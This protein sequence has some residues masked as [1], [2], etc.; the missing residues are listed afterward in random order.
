MR[1]FPMKWKTLASMPHRLFF[2]GGACQGIAAVLWWLLE[3]SG[4]FGGFD[5]FLPWT[6]PPVWAH[7][8]LII[9]GFFSFFI[10]GFLFTFFPNWLDAESIPS[11]NYLLSFF[12]FSS[13]TVLFYVGL[14]F[15]KNIL[16]LAVLSAVAGWGIGAI[17]LIR[18]LLP[19]RTPEKIHLSLMTFF[20]ILGEVGLLSFLLWLLTDQP[21]WLKAA[22]VI[23]IWFFLLPLIV[24]VSHLVI[25]FFS[26]AALQ[27]YRVVQPL[28]LLSILLGGICL[29]GLWEG[30]QTRSSFWI[31]DTV[32]LLFAS[33]LSFV[34]SFWKSVDIKFLFML[35][36]S[37]A[38]F[39]VALVLDLLQSLT[40]LWSHETLSVLGFAPLHALTIGFFSSMVVGMSTRVT[41]GHS[42]RRVGVDGAAWRIFLLFQIA[43]LLRVLAD[44]FPAGGLFN[45]G[46]Y[47][48]S[49]LLWIAGISS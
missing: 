24:T 41:L 43:A 32:L 36:L 47:E 44:L 25:P 35:H 11:R 20:V 21:L 46:G 34:W 30:I 7:A 5:S 31:P 29:R 8:Y 28:W 38:W 15:D 26:K 3:L 6:I 39:S 10:F 4:R 1:F 40:F 14:I 9:Y 37:F 27:N 42:G 17:S 33:Y 2:L 16:L 19:A 12:L 45:A 22:R 49:A 23:G 13:G 18:I 48:G